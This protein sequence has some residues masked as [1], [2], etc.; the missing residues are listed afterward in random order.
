MHNLCNNGTTSTGP[1]TPPTKLEPWPPLAF[2]APENRTATD[3][4][5]SAQACTLVR[6]KKRRPK[7]A[8][9]I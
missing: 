9:F 5:L 6:R 3:R 7:A 1:A 8:L 2:H 4:S